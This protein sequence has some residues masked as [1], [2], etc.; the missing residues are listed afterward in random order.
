[1]FIF[2][3]E[4]EPILQV[5][6]GKTLE[7]AKME[8]LEEE[9]LRYM[10]EEQK[11]FHKMREDEIAEAQKLESIELRKK[12]E[13]ERRKQQHKVKKLEKIA[14]HKKYTCREV[15]KSFCS[16]LSTHV[17]TSLSVRGMMV[18][19]LETEI[20]E[21]VVPWLYDKMFDFLI[22]E[23]LHNS[24]TNELLKDSMTVDEHLHRSMIEKEHKRIED[25]RKEAERQLK[26]KLYEKEQRRLERERK[27]REEELRKL[28]EDIDEKFIKAGEQAEGIVFQEI[29]TPN[30]DFIGKKII[31][32]VGGPFVQIAI[33]LS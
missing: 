6:C 15:A 21:Q 2:D 19:K 29:S 5:L 33:V 28:K 31:G 32:A 14:A 3:D 23:E 1:M 8:V 27:R 17:L 12:Q 25:E 30:A 13:I 26:Q 16:P 11:H 20:H 10:R 4:V 24:N 18:P 9:E 7:H 22:D